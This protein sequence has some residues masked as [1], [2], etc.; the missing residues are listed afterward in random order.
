MKTPYWKGRTCHASFSRSIEKFQLKLL[1]NCEAHVMINSCLIRLRLSAVWNIRAPSRAEF[2]F[3][4][5]DVIISNS[6]FHLN[7]S[8]GCAKF[9]DSSGII[10][11]RA[12]QSHCCFPCKKKYQNSNLSLNNFHM[13]FLHKIILS[14]EIFSVIYYSYI[15]FVGHSAKINANKNSKVRKISGEIFSGFTNLK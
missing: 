1:H 7:A 10:G 2:C 3:L 4:S 9:Y 14:T 8:R 15:F 6:E 5:R 13:R 11:L 12:K